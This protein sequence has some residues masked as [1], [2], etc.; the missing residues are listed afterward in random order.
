LVS[1]SSGH[2]LAADRHPLAT[3]R[4]A[5]QSTLDPD[6]QYRG[7]LSPPVM[8]ILTIALAEAADIAILGANVIVTSRRGLSD[9]VNDDT[10]LLLLRLALFG[11]FAL[12]LAAR[13]FNAA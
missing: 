7:T 12:V 2:A 8:L 4:Y 3:L 10:S 5:D 11:S 1:V 6:R 9:L 13:R